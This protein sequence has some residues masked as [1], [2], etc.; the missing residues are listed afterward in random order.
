MT[1]TRV[2]ISE[3]RHK[4]L[5]MEEKIQ[6]DVKEQ[7]LKDGI[8][9]DI[10]HVEAKKDLSLMHKMENL[11][12]INIS[13]LLMQAKEQGMGTILSH[14]VKRLHNNNQLQ[15]MVTKSILLIFLNLAPNH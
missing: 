12:M 7:C 14:Q 8:V 6:K 13:A 5:R 11:S 15:Q 4:W 9:Y 10:V 1:H 2:S 3:H